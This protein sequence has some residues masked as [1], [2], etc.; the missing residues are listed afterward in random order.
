MKNRSFVPSDSQNS[1]HKMPVH[2]ASSKR[3]VS[4]G[5]VFF[6]FSRAVFCAVPC[7]TERLE[8][9]TVHVADGCCKTGNGKRGT[10]NGSLRTSVQW[11]ST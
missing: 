9:A 4:H 10:G 5:T 3:S 7:I 11:K 8:E 1:E 6:I 2:V